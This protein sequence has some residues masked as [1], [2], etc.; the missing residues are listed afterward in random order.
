MRSSNF[1]IQKI[2]LDIKTQIIVS[3]GTEH[4]WSQLPLLALTILLLPLPYKFLILKR[5]GLIL[6]SHS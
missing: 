5:R 2:L 1:T 6:T 3:A 4:P